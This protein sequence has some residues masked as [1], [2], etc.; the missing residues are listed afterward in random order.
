MQLFDMPFQIKSLIALGFFAVLIWIGLELSIKRQAFSVKCCMI[1]STNIQIQ[2][3]HVTG[4]VVSLS[5]FK[6]FFHKTRL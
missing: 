1:S 6:Y 4:K 5:H 2:L 3:I